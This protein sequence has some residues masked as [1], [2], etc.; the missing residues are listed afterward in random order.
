VGIQP[1][2]IIPDPDGIFCGNGD[3][4]NPQYPSRGYLLGPLWNNNSG[5]GRPS[6]GGG[7]SGTSGGGIVSPLPPGP[8][9]AVNYCGQPNNLPTLVAVDP[10]TTFSQQYDYSWLDP[11][12]STQHYYYRYEGSWVPVVGLAVD[13]A[14]MIVDGASV[15]ASVGLGV[16]GVLL[17]AKVQFVMSTAEFAWAGYLH[18]NGQY[19][20]VYDHGSGLLDSTAAR[21]TNSQAPLPIAGFASSLLSAYNNMQVISNGFVAYPVTSSW[22]STFPY[23]P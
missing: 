12:P 8:A 21:Y 10:F 13:V 17:S 19:E 6:G 15:A 2:T 23:N 7:D 14:G 9:C 4:V 18:A 20:A 16:P 5:S 22:H 1:D 11:D 3:W